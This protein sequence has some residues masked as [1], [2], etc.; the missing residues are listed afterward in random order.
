MIDDRTLLNLL[1][2]GVQVAIVAIAGGLLPR[3]LRVGSPDVRHVYWRALL[4]ICLAL[5][6]IQ[7]W[8]LPESPPPP[9]VEAAAGAPA[10]AQSPVGATIR[11]APPVPRQ[12]AQWSAAVVPALLLVGLARI[13]WLLGGI[14]RLGRLRRRGTRVSEDVAGAW[15]DAAVRSVEI[16]YVPAIRQP[17]TFG[18]RRPVV[19]LPDSLRTAEPELRSVVIAHELWHVRR[20]D[21]LW[22]LAEEAIAS[23]LWFHPAIVWLISRVQRAR[24]EVVD[25]LTVLQTNARR[26][27][28]RAL[29]MFA[30]EPAPVT[31]AP[32]ARRR[33]LFHRMQLISKEG[34]M[35]SRRVVL[36]CAVGLSVVIAA[37]VGASARFPLVG[38]EPSVNRPG[39]PLQ[40]APPRDP[41]PAGGQQPS[42]REA[43][44]RSAIAAAPGS[45][46]PYLELAKLQEDR[47]AIA[48]AESTL[49]A[50][51]A[52]VPNNTVVLRA[53]AGFY[54][55]RGDFQ[56][57]IQALEDVAALDPSD[58]AR[59]HLVATYYWEEAQKDPALAPA[60]R[61][62][63]IEAGIAA[64]DRALALDGSYVEALV[65]KNILLRMQAN[66][67]TDPARR[68]ALVAEADGLRTRAMDL[69]RSQPGRGI[70]PPPPPPPPAHA[71]GASGQPTVI[72]EV[73]PEYPPIALAA[74]VQGIIVLDVDVDASG[75]VAAARVKR[76]IPLLDQAAR[77][78]VRQWE[79][80]PAR[81]K[82][83]A[84]PATVVV[85]VPFRLPR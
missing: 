18:V 34:A 60:E 30:D 48:E 73:P 5:P 82:G 7:P 4:V 65:Y 64:E 37:G 77:D 74:R 6:A 85:Q 26:T 21:W 40:Q 46:A 56:R 52:A 45:S 39:L 66:M 50:A 20:R 76:G 29:L 25:E 55:R 28:L 70:P 14:V 17:V 2:W 10:A 12:P 1:A 68:Q 81:I 41:K 71:A 49:T 57:T 53:I 72:K 61:L 9:V 58:P 42:D 11:P 79:F 83:Q 84:M 15:Q 38:S 23:L 75:K 43:A 33:H 67:E 36:F 3:L 35:S 69:R 27:Y 19:C 78:A 16:L 31:V 63:Y 54:T 59:H 80:A 44:L 24:E 22:L 47:G 51:R 62:T 13:A 8:Q 32:F